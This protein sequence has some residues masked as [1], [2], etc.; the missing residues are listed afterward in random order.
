M[1]IKDDCVLHLHFAVC[2]SSPEVRNTLSRWY[3]LL[4]VWAHMEHLHG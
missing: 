3:M 2:T 1:D 4:W